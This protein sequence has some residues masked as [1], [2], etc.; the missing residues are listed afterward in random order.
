MIKSSVSLSIFEATPG[1]P[2]LYS[3]ATEAN[4][5]E[6]KE[7]GYDGV[8]LFV[9]NP[10]DQDTK[11]AINLL[12]KYELGIGVIMPAALAGEGLF[13]GDPNPAIRE[14]AVRR[15][16]EIVTLASEVGGMVSLG[17]VRGSC[18]KDESMEVFE[19]RFTES[20]IKM[21]EIAQPLGVDLLIEPINRYEINTI[22][23]A[24]EG[25]EYI[26]RVNLPLYL[27]LDIFHMNIEDVDVLETLM[28]GLPYTKHIHFLDSNRL[29]PSM[30]HMPMEVYYRALEHVGYDG[31]LCL[32]ALPKPDTKTCA[33]KGA[34][35]F[36]K[37][38]AK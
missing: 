27:M 28:E 25:I 32:E 26:K 22:N 29:A 14:E 15:I 1:M 38:R 3:G 24:K 9:R 31:Y 4:I 23:S 13:L 2:V 11:N 7:L 36:N 30:G 6:I 20:C 17:L 33:E 8:D 12:Q 5:R 37:M 35:F 18:D 16:G 34:E 21:L 10:H 19:A